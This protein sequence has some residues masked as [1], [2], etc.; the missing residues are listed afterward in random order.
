MLI[1]L[2]AC[3]GTTTEP[4]PHREVVMTATRWQPH[5]I[6]AH[7]L[8][9]ELVDAHPPASGGGP[10]QEFLVQR[11]E[12]GVAALRIGPAITLAWWRASVGAALPFG[13][14]RAVTVC[15]R[16]GA[17]QEVSAPAD[18]ATGLVPDPG[19]SGFGHI[20]QRTPARIHVAVAGTTARGTPFVA[21]WTV[22]AERRDAL[23]ADEDH[24]FASIRCS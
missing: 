13:P 18:V 24:F 15:G 21:T 14:E 8:T 9:I 4:T 17:R 10:E 22:D 12:T 11:L 19:G 7:G 16:P 20:E 2:A 6:A 5:T 23:R 3:G 1:A